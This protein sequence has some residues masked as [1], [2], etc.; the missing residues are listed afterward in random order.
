MELS[1]VQLMEE[2]PRESIEEVYCCRDCCLRGNG[3][4]QEPHGAAIM[5]S[6]V[7]SIQAVF[8]ITVL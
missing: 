7:K 6:L 4:T 2:Q 5:N 1:S 3:T 8:D